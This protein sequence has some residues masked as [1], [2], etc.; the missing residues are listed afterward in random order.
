[1]TEEDNRDRILIHLARGGDGAIEFCGATLADG[2][3]HYQEAQILLAE[4]IK[5]L[6]ERIQGEKAV[7]ALKESMKLELDL[8]KKKAL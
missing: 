1:M 7:N 6:E 3:A 2:L 4:E 8:P 5:L